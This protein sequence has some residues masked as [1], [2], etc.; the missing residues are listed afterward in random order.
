MA[1]VP[2]LV[3]LSCVAACW[4][5]VVLVYS[6]A[7]L[8][9]RFNKLTLLYLLTY[10]LRSHGRSTRSI[11]SAWM[12]TRVISGIHASAPASS[13]V[14][15]LTSQRWR[16]EEHTAQKVIS[17]LCLTIIII[18]VILTCMWP[19]NCCFFL[20]WGHC[21]CLASLVGPVRVLSAVMFLWNCFMNK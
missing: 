4:L 12:N 9:V 6:A 20:Y 10:V 14:C 5:C 18:I 11:G 13:C 8:Q 15:W 16:Y 21:E 3:E 1:C 19:S 2:V 17:L 7:K